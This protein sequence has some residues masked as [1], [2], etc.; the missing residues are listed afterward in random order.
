VAGLNVAETQAVGA[1]SYDFTDAGAVLG[2]EQLLPKSLK[3]AHLLQQPV[4]RSRLLHVLK[5]DGQITDKKFM[6]HSK[7]LSQ[8]M[9]I[10]VSLTGKCS[11]TLTG[12]H[13]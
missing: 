5:I 13:S 12:A 11:V 10:C 3:V 4:L 9:G 6:P 8:L 1:N 2:A 7:I